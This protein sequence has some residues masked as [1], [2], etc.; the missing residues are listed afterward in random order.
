MHE[1]VPFPGETGLASLRLR[2]D[3]RR[4]GGMLSLVWTLEGARDGL[5]LPPPAPAPR[6]ADRLWED[7]CF[8]CFAAPAGGAAYWE[9]N[10]AP[11]GDWNLYRFSGYREDMRW[12]ERV[13]G[14]VGVTA[15][16]TAD[17]TWRL[18][19]GIDLR[20][21]PELAQAAL[22]VGLSAVLVG[23]APSYRAL[24]HPGSRPDF[25]QRAAFALHLRAAR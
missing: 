23:D 6:R 3:A 21:V 25:H 18:A 22:D 19:A 5:H 24:A 9:L 11:S 8:E 7:T 17:G 14:L 12:E 1:L 16:V 4:G 10:V 2:A 13:E 20:R 15:M